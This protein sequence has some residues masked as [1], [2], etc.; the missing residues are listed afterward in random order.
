MTTPEDSVFG[1]I[2]SVSGNDE[3]AQLR[4]LFS[5]DGDLLMKTEIPPGLII[6]MSKALL[7]ANATGSTVLMDYCVTILKAQVSKDR[8]GRLEYLEAM[9]SRRSGGDDEL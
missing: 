7:I 4:E 1:Q 5:A 2:F 8:K 6:P 3:G 9:M